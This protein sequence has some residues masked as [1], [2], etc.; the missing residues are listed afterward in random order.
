MLVRVHTADVSEREGGIFL[1][2]GKL[3][4]LM[5]EI[6]EILSPEIVSREFSGGRDS[7]LLRASC[8][9]FVGKAIMHY[10]CDARVGK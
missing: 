10:Q 9:S 8:V 5:Q 1:C 3:Q 2:E 6:L 7:L 4:D